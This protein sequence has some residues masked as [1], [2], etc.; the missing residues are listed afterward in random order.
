MM[1]W[2]KNAHAR[3]RRSKAN[4]LPHTHAAV[5]LVLALGVCASLTVQASRRRSHQ[6]PVT[7]PNESVRQVPQSGSAEFL[8]KDIPA[9]EDAQA[10]VVATLR[11]DTGT[12]TGHVYQDDGVTPLAFDDGGVILYSADGSAVEY[13]ASATIQ[14]DGSYT[15]SGLPEG[16]YKLHCAPRSTT[17]AMEWY[18]D[19]VF[20]DAATPVQVVAANT[21][22]ADFVL[23][24]FGQISGHIYEDDGT[25]PVAFGFVS[26]CLLSP[27]GGWSSWGESMVQ[28][29]SYTIGALRSADYLLRI[30]NLPDAWFPEWYSGVD[31]ANDATP[32]TVAGPDTTTVDITL[33]RGGTLSGHV[34][35]SDGT[36]A[37]SSASIWI[38]DADDMD[39]GYWLSTDQDGSF[40]KTV[41]PGNYKLRAH[42]D[43]YLVEFYP[44]TA[45]WDWDMWFRASSVTVTAGT[46]TEC[47]FVLEQPVEA[48]VVNS[49]SPNVGTNDGSTS[50]TVNGYGFADGITVELRDDSRAVLAGADVQVAAGTELSCTFDLQGQNA[51]PRDV[52]LTRADGVSAR[53][54]NGFF[55][56]EP[57]PLSVV[58]T[59]PLDP[60]TVSGS[61]PE[62][63][64]INASTQ[65]AYVLCESS[66]TMGIVDLQTHELVKN[67]R[68]PGPL[69]WNTMPAVDEANNRV[70]VPMPENHVL[71]AF[72]GQTGEQL[73]SIDVGVAPSAALATPS[74]AWVFVANEASSTVSIIAGATLTVVGTVP[75][76]THPID[77]AG[78]ADTMTVYTANSW[79]GG[80]TAIIGGSRAVVDINLGI[81]P[82]SVVVNLT[83]NRVYALDWSGNVAVIDGATNTHLTTIDLDTDGTEYIAVN[84]LT[85]WIYVGGEDDNRLWPID[86]DTNTPADPIELGDCVNSIDFDPVTNRIYVADD[87]EGSV[88]IVDGDPASATFHTVLGKVGICN[89]C[90][91]TMAVVNGDLGEVYACDPDIDALVV[92]S[93]EQ[94]QITDSISLLGGPLIPAA[95]STR[96]Q[97]WVSHTGPNGARRI[98]SATRQVTSVATGYP[99]LYGMLNEEDNWFYMS[100]CAGTGITPTFTGVNGSTLDVLNIAAPRCPHGPM[101]LDATNKR[102]YMIS[103]PYG[104]TGGNKVSILDTNP[105]NATFNTVLAVPDTG[106]NPYGV[107]V[108]E[109]TRRAYIANTGDG[110]VT[111]LLDTQVLA[112]VEVGND[113]CSV[114]VNETTNRIYVTNCDDGTVSVIDGSS[115]QVEATID[116][117]GDP[118]RFA[119][120]STTNRVYVGHD[121][122][123]YL[124]VIDGATNTVAAQ[125]ELSLSVEPSVWPVVNETDNEVYCPDWDSGVLYVIDG[126]TDTIKQV[127]AVGRAPVLASRNTTTGDVYVTNYGSNTVSIISRGDPDEFAVHLTA[128]RWELVSFPFAPAR[129]TPQDLIPGLIAIYSFDTELS[130]YVVPASIE[131]T[132]GYWI[133]VAQDADVVVQST[134]TGRAPPSLLAGWNL[135]GPDATCTLHAPD[136]I[137]LPGWA[138]DN[139][140]QRYLPIG[141]QSWIIRGRAY[142]LKATQACDFELGR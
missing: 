116:I 94:Q 58:D 118:E 107:A 115:N 16:T 23:C 105:A 67:V 24:R 65:R 49:I 28:D 100:R 41:A 20:G 75:V 55:V 110:T 114:G 76:G 3:Q 60:E 125:I 26:A 36:T 84:P 99:H 142:W 15:F 47:D 103:I 95:D 108:N 83:T 133:M 96:G 64:A 126:A 61:D 72:D 1:G 40:E 119:V 86:G 39:T 112:T 7:Q 38:S 81:G 85:N 130:V 48:L 29:G 123:R 82:N 77:L 73:A 69:E 44:N 124:T 27:G 102:L 4:S 37:I 35:Q 46:E 43:G 128:W 57:E 9:R 25:T 5:R 51:G 71:L 11:D 131:A 138:W 6:R 70:Y 50:V 93:M 120:N 10:T 121:E 62:R 74:G 33:R 122:F 104:G 106:D 111:V 87:G 17:W 21:S 136:D 127:L 78:N 80:C 90:A 52:V 2:N 113:P 140:A 53:L 18:D 139:D 89:D 101:A 14:S 68:L 135:R 45:G 59:V 129:T 134:R 34:Y 42:A 141:E 8:T 88:Y 97:C 117:G 63:V 109:Q 54:P 137:E 98:D 31:N 132:V 32:V 56:S 30:S 19:T 79:G 66:Q 12:I 92:I 91:V 22:V 13:V